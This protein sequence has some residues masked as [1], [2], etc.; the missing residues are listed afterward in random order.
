MEQATP[1]SRN[2]FEDLGFDPDEAHNLK[3]RAELM[4]AIT[5]LIDR[6][7]M[8]QRE[9]AELFGV[10]QPRVSDIVRGKIELFTIDA[11][12]KMLSSAGVK[13]SVL[14]TGQGRGIAGD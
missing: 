8:T 4:M 3:I 11:L 7:G 6:R 5:R 2:V 10:T 9:A 1:S 13:V 14:V 12:V